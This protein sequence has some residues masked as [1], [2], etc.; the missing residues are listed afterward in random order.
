MVK[1]K[2]RLKKVVLP[3]AFLMR[4]S[5]AIL[6]QF[7]RSGMTT[8]LRFATI[9]PPKARGDTITR[10]EMFRLSAGTKHLLFGASLLENPS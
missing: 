10:K 7:R 1:I 8:S 3:K 2:Y 6:L 4:L 9:A 5:V